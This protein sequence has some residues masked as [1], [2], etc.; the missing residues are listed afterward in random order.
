VIAIR[1][2][3]TAECDRLTDVTGAELAASVSAIQSEILQ[4]SVVQ[5]PNRP[6]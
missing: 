5:K 2:D 3:P 6:L 4:Q 1:I